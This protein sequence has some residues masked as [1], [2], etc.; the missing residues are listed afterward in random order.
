MAKKKPA[1]EHVILILKEIQ[2]AI[3]VWVKSLPNCAVA[4]IIKEL[5]CF[6][7]IS[8]VSK[9]GYTISAIILVFGKQ[10]KKVISMHYILKDQKIAT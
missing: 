2:P 7:D 3:H 10:P 6:G 9:P 8:Y 4:P 1:Q 5:P